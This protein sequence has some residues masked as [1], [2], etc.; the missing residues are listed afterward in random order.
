[1]KKQKTRKIILRIP[2]DCENLSVHIDKSGE[3]AIQTGEASAVP[4]RMELFREKH[5]ELLSTCHWMA[6][7]A[8]KASDLAIKKLDEGEYSVEELPAFLGL[9]V[10]R[11]AELKLLMA[12]LDA[13]VSSDFSEISDDELGEIMD[14]L[15]ASLLSMEEAVDRADTTL[16]RVVFSNICREEISRE[17]AAELERETLAMLAERNPVQ[18]GVPV[19]EDEGE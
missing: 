7:D 9:L 5:K 3:V 2:E 12:S 17:L 11:K 18:K 14:P 8:T 10:Q 19:P 1:M 15:I 6:D 13:T 16:D 4:S